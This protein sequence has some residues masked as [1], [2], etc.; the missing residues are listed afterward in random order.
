[1]FLLSNRSLWRGLLL[2]NVFNR[3]LRRGLLIIIIIFN[4]SLLRGLLIGII[5]N[6]FCRSGL[7]CGRSLLLV[8]L[9]LSLSLSLSPSLSFSFISWLPEGVS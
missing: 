6:I 5:I 9:S 3:S 4:R 1:M 7:L 2:N 8:L